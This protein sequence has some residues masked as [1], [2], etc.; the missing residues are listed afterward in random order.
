MPLGGV[1][2]GREA[3]RKRTD[4]REENSATA[5]TLPISIFTVAK[6]TSIIPFQV[7][8]SFPAPFF[9]PFFNIVLQRPL[10]LK[11]TRH[12]KTEYVTFYSPKPLFLTHFV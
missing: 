11:Y 1:A 7:L 5:E 9:L 4:T 3:S 6:R 8:L 10:F 2:T 12:W